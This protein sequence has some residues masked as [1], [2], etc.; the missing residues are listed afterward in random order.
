MRAAGRDHQIEK[1]G[2]SLRK[3]MPFLN[4]VEIVDGQPQ[5]A[6]TSKG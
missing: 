2:A 1:V 5:A 3:A 6:A 4:P